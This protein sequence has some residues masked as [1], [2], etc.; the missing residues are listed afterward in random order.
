MKKNQW[1]TIECQIL[2]YDKKQC[3]IIHLILICR[4]SKIKSTDFSITKK[5]QSLSLKLKVVKIST[6]DFKM[7]QFKQLTHLFRKRIFLKVKLLKCQEWNELYDIQKWKILNDLMTYLKRHSFR[8]QLRFQRN[9]LR[10]THLE[11]ALM[12]HFCLGTVQ[13]E[14]LKMELHTMIQ[15]D[16]KTWSLLSKDGK[17]DVE[18]MTN[19]LMLY[20]VYQ[21]VN[22]FITWF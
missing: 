4:A 7:V 21:F 9:Y 19:Y 16:G 8:K 12:I 3:Q 17:K 22:S 13:N 6:K 1:T 20:R 5:F 2:A 11:Q 10:K 18:V 14:F 15:N